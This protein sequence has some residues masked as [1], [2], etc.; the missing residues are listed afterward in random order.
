MVSQSRKPS[1]QATRIVAPLL[2]AHEL[3]SPQLRIATSG[4]TLQETR[5]PKLLASRAVPVLSGRS[6]FGLHRETAREE[7]SSSTRIDGVVCLVCQCHTSSATDPDAQRQSACTKA[8]SLRQRSSHRV[9]LGVLSLLAWTVSNASRRLSGSRPR[10]R[11]QQYRA[12]DPS[13]NAGAP[14][15]RP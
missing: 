6:S 1:A 2:D 9:R 15:T 14:I 11:R 7:C 3:A 4:W 12:V 8:G 10:P 5:S 13:M